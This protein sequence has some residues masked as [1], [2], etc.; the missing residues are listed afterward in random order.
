[1]GQQMAIDVPA[2]IAVRMVGNDT[3]FYQTILTWYKK[4]RALCSTALILNTLIF[5]DACLLGTEEVSVEL[6]E[7]LIGKKAKN[8]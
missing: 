8:E 6:D 5:D 1:M 7:S 3:I 4:F 2:Y